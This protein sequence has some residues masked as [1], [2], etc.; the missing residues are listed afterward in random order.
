MDLWA[1]CHALNSRN[2]PKKK[3]KDMKNYNSIHVAKIIF[4][5]WIVVNFILYFGIVFYALFRG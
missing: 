1:V 2:R 4:G 3:T 5:A